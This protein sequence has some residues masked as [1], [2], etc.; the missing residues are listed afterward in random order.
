MDFVKYAARGLQNAG[1]VHGDRGGG[2]AAPGPP[3]STP[4]SIVGSI[5]FT[6]R[7]SPPSLRRSLIQHSVVRQASASRLLQSESPAGHGVLSEEATFRKEQNRRKLSK[8][9]LLLIAAESAPRAADEHL[10]ERVVSGRRAEAPAVRA[11]GPLARAAPATQAPPHSGPWPHRRGSPTSPARLRPHLAQGRLAAVSTAASTAA[12]ELSDLLPT[13]V[14]ARSPNRSR[15]ILQRHPAR[16]D[17]WVDKQPLQGSRSAGVADDAAAELDRQKMP[18]PA[19]PEEDIIAKYMRA[20]PL[21]P[22]A[23]P[24][25]RRR[26]ATACRRATAGSWP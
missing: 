23:A 24:S 26:V 12:F 7:L 13:A 17:R 25:P 4:R 20:E 6:R 22:P 2:G 11:R 9:D 18:G 10:S 8:F 15:T 5:S 14:R 1:A 16:A 21:P 3:S 19:T